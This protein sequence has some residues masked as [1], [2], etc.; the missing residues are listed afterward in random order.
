MNISLITSKGTKYIAGLAYLYQQELARAV[1]SG[2][3][4][5]IVVNL[6]KCLD[7]EAVL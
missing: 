5:R 4:S 3:N 7:P 1:D 2:P 6:T